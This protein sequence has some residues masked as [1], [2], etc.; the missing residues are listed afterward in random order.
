MRNFEFLEPSSIEEASRML[1][2]AGENSRVMA[3]GTALMLAMRQRMLMPSTIV[4][5]AG[6]PDLKGIHYDPQQGL[7]LGALSRHIDIAESPVVIAHYPMVAEMAAKLANPQVRH[8]GT[9]GGNICY[10]DPSTDPATCLI[11]LNAQIVL[12]SSRGR[13]MMPLEHFLV[14]YF[15]TAIE[16]D[17]VVVDVRVPPLPNG[18]CGHYL[19]FRKTAA[20]H[21]PLVNIAVAAQQEQGQCQQARIVVGASTPVPQRLKEAESMLKGQSVSDRLLQQVSIKAAEEVNAVSDNRASE[22]FRREMVRV[23]TYRCLAH[24]FGLPQE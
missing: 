7:T 4:S 18:F 22:S 1:A 17:E 11:A 8:Q 10:G 12:G 16:S 6:I 23:N 13:R 21:R 14:D 20:E 15:Q 5:V 3:G 2:D 19:R 9:L 24:A